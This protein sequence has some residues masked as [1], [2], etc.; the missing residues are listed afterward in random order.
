LAPKND[1]MIWVRPASLDDLES[2]VAIYN[3]AWREGF[4]DI[5]DAATFA[6][7][8]FDSDRR[9]EVHDQLLDESIS[10][11]V[12]EVDARVIGFSGVSIDDGTPCLDDMWVHPH[13]WGRGAAQGLIAA[14]ED[15]HRAGGTRR[16]TTW[17]PEG[18]RR[19]RGFIEKMGWHQTGRTEPMVLYLN[20]P[21]LLFEYEHI[22]I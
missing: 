9:D 5:F 2:L 3:A 7:D 18:G 1:E 12:A 15:E 22:L 21:Q 17:V 6:D 16:L 20:Q 10:T 14:I 19:A 4:A 11:L 8:R 13:A